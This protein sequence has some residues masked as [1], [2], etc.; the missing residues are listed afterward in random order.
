MAVIPIVTIPNSILN[1]KCK[2][3]RFGDEVLKVIR[4]LK[5]TLNSAKEPEGA[6][7]S[8]PQI[9]VSQRICVVREFLPDPTNPEKPL[10]REYVLINPKI[11]SKSKEKDLDYEGCLSVP[12]IYGK[13]ERA[14]KIKVKFVDKT[15]EKRQISALGF[16]AR[17]IQHEVDHLDGILFTSKVVGDLKTEKE[18]EESKI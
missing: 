10:I 3:A 2:K 12:D 16:F 6:G 11:V 17:T 14:R 18:M 1:R 8:A 9:G 7:L 5:D 15:G 13:V 4:N